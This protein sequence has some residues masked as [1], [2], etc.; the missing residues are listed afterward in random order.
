MTDNEIICHWRRMEKTKR[1]VFYLAQL[2]NRRIT[3][4]IH[5]LNRCGLLKGGWID[6]EKRGKAEP[7]RHQRP[8]G[9]RTL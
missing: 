3:D 9:L 8:Q 2:S 6:N 7:I 5:L 1:S 4:I